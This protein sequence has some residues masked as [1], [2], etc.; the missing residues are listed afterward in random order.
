MAFKKYF[1]DSYRVLA[2]YNGKEAL[3][4][5]DKDEPDLILLDL[6]MP[7][8]GGFEFL[9]RLRKDKKRTRIP[10]IVYTS[11]DLSSEEERILGEVTLAVVKK[12]ETSV[13][14]LIATLNK[15]LNKLK[16]DEP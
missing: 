11:K 3:E 13:E 8:M 5:L 15:T 2:A 4:V 16:T 9:E 12:G 10:V 14:E 6:I 1:R 7:V